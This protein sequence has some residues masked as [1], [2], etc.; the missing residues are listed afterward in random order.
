MSGYSYLSLRTPSSAFYSSGSSDSELSAIS[1]VLVNSSSSS[2]SSSSESTKNYIFSLIAAGLISGY[3]GTASC[4]SGL[5]VKISSSSSSS[6]LMENSNSS[7]AL[8]VGDAVI[9]GS[10]PSVS[11]VTLVIVFSS[12]AVSPEAVLSSSSDSVLAYRSFLICYS[13]STFYLSFIFACSSAKNWERLVLYGF[14]IC[15]SVFF[16]NSS[17]VAVQSS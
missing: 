11:P 9:N 17:T 3:S 16:Y 13:C 7:V 5:E 1:T 4:S 10:L 14:A 12:V 8:A 15:C 6:S 2:P